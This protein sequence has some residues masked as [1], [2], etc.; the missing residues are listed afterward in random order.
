MDMKAF[1]R[2]IVA[3][4]KSEMTQKPIDVYTIPHV[5]MGIVSYIV[6][7]LFLSL[8]FDDFNTAYI[9]LSPFFKSIDVKYISIISVLFWA[10]I[11]EYVENFILAKT[12]LKFGKRQDSLEN[13][14]T[15]VVFT[16]IGGILG[17]AA[18]PY[19]WYAMIGF[20]C[21]TLYNWVFYKHAMG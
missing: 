15:D 16:G 14:L 12:R 3:Q 20:I 2:K 9:F 13:S 18:G 7:F 11:W 4:N 17:L 8:F 6:F 1:I 21:M 5:L 10:V 19:V